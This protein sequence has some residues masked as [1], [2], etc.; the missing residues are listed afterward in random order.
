MNKTYIHY[1]SSELGQLKFDS[2]KYYDISIPLVFDS[3]NEKRNKQVTAYGVE[4]AQSNPYIAGDFIGD[5][6]EGSAVN[7][8]KIEITPHCNGT[9]TECVGHITDERI[10]IY[11]KLSDVFCLADLVTVATKTNSKDNYKPELESKDSVINLDNIKDKVNATPKAS[12]ALIIRTKPNNDSKLKRDYNQ[13]PGAFFTN[14]AMKFISKLPYKHILVDLPSL[15][16]AN[17]SGYLSNHRIWWNIDLGSKEKN[18]SWQNN[19]TIT[20]FIYVPNEIRDGKY[21]LN[22]QITSFLGDAS[23]SRPIIFP[24]VD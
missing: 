2:N 18:G 14:D 7:F 12:D 21:L 23:P 1:Q 3:E 5:T 11:D 8:E 24:L 19:R 6:R 20:E 10:H 13:N 17:D 15:D 16:K 22:L 4:P 9:H